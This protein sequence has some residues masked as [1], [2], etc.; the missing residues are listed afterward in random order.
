MSI[1]V[2]FFLLFSCSQTNNIVTWLI[3]MTKI[4]SRK[5]VSLPYRSSTENHFLLYLFSRTKK[6]IS[7]AILL[8]YNLWFNTTLISNS[9]PLRKIFEIQMI[10]YVDI[11]VYIYFPSATIDIYILLFLFSSGEI[12]VDFLFLDRCIYLHKTSWH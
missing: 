5:S 8:L 11:Y 1:R 9:L 6:S 7:Y 4:T 12:P 2:S 10:Y 3:I